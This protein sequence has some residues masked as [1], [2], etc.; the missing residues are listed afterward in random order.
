LATY[1]WLMKDDARTLTYISGANRCKLCWL[2]KVGIQNTPRISAVTVAADRASH[3]KQIPVPNAMTAA[4]PM[5]GC[6]ALRQ[7]QLPGQIA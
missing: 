6:L 5:A 7:A 1:Q 2:C 4:A 3:L